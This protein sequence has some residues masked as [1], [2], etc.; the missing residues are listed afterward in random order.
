MGDYYLDG[1]VFLKSGVSL[2]GD[3]SEDDSPYETQFHVHGSGTGAD[4]VINADGVSGAY[5]SLV[6][7]NIAGS[8]FNSTFGDRCTPCRSIRHVTAEAYPN[9]HLVIILKRFSHCADD[10]AMSASEVNTDSVSST[11]RFRTKHST[12]GYYTSRSFST[13]RIFIVLEQRAKIMPTRAT[14]R[15]QRL[16]I[17]DNSFDSPDR[18]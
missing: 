15:H 8:S 3:W 12:R 6:M 1:P 10:T 2:I 7:R 17:N 13:D 9:M 5:V 16:R 18:V 14:S 11:H 4:G